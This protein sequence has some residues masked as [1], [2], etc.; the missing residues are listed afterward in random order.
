MN[1]TILLTLTTL[2]A[3]CGGDASFDP[4][5]AAERELR[6]GECRPSGCSSHV[7]SDQDVITTCE[8]LPEYAC[9]QTATCERQADGEC[10]WTET[11]TLLTCIREAREPEVTLSGYYTITPIQCGGNGWE[12]PGVV[13]SPNL[14][15]ELG[16]ALGWLEASGVAVEE[17]GFVNPVEPYAVCLACS[18]PRGDR[19]V[20]KADDNQATALIALGFEPM[21]RGGHAIATQCDNPWG[22]RGADEARNVAEYAAGLGV[23]LEEVGF[24][25]PSHFF[26]ACL[27]CSC[28]RGDRVF[29]VPASG[30]DLS[31]LGFETL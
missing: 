24:L 8:F 28:P 23:V 15:G 5:R 19:L 25:Q 3:A 21:T 22:D 27:A 30:E 16:R 13:P 10:G 20:V 18:C 29:V 2:V 26:T 11:E 12:A 17:L 4:T 31:A 7:C 6:T 1:R 14:S 9:Y